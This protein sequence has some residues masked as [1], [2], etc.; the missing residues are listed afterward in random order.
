MFIGQ[1]RLRRKCSKKILKCSW[2]ELLGEEEELID[3]KLLRIQ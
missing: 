3:S 2:R 1:H